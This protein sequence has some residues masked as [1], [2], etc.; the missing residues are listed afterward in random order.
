MVRELVGVQP[1]EEVID[2]L[3]ESLFV[4]RKVVD[5]L[6]VQVVGDLNYLSWLF[7]RPVLFSELHFHSTLKFV[8]ETRQYCDSVVT[9]LLKVVEELRSRVLAGY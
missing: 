3:F 2:E 4:N 9:Q 1:L 7:L 8:Q 5:V 6:H